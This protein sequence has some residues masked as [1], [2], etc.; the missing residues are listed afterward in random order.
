MAVAVQSYGGRRTG[1]TGIPSWSNAVVR[2]LFAE[3]AETCK[4]VNIFDRNIISFMGK[5]LLFARI[6]IFRY[7]FV[8]VIFI[9]LRANREFKFKKSKFLYLNKV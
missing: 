4:K 6:P 3:G 8:I 1:N 2:R 9:T 5:G 7:C